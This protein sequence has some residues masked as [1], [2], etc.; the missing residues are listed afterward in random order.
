[1]EKNWEKQNLIHQF[2]FRG[3]GKG[4]ETPMGNGASFQYPRHRTDHDLESRS[5]ITI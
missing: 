2:R 1:M 3:G 4:R 5:R